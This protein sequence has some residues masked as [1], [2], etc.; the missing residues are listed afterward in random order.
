MAPVSRRLVLATLCLAGIAAAY[1]LGGLD[2]LAWDLRPGSPI[3]QSLGIAAALLL[4][5]SLV[6]VP[7]RRSDGGNWEKPAAR[8][9]HGFVG[10]LG[11]SLA[12]MHSQAALREWSTLV[13]CAVAGLLATGLYG[14]VI[15]PLRVGSTFGRYA[16]P[17]A[18]AAQPDTDTTASDALL[19]EKRRL[20]GTMAA[21]ARE[22]EFVLRWHH[23]TRDPRTA[24]RY[25]RLALAERRAIARN[26]L[27]ASTEIPVFERHWRRVHLGLAGLFVIGI[28][29]HVVTTVFFAGY[30][31]DGREV[32]WWHVAR[33]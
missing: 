22:G 24:W 32:Y 29:A 16:I 14:M 4:L 1:M 2:R 8:S 28:L 27:S 3:G 30:V 18:A 26:P 25:R 21:D 12:I 10:L 13:L 19:A 5:S 7:L 6:Y 31:A 20:L 33:W 11:T 17:Y 15:A 23:W 9:L